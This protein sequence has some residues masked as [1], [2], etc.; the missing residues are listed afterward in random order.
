MACYDTEENGRSEYTWETMCSLRDTVNWGKHRL[1]VVDNDCCQAT[2]DIFKDFRLAS[3][4]TRT[5]FTLITLSENIGTAKAV[6]LGLKLRM[7]GEHCIKLDND[8]VIHRSGWVDELEAV[9][10]RDNTI[11]ITAL[12]RKDL[13]QHPDNPDLTFKSELVMLPHEAGQKW[14]VVEKSRDIMGTCTMFNYRLLDKIGYMH[15]PGKYGFD[16][17][18]M[19]LRSLL[20]G[21]WNCFLPHIDLDH[22]DSGQNDY[23]EVKRQQANEVWYEYQSMHN[24]YVEGRLPLYYDGGFD[25]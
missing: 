3:V 7:H 23:S 17:Q 25:D 11:G 22:I 15:Q 18:L 9:I 5:T 19:A 1:C 4:I 21:F 2:K 20:A 6:N 8:I 24:D 12:K 16:D 13:A 10:E 14:I